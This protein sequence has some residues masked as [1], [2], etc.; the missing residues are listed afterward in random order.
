MIVKRVVQVLVD[1]A[2]V[3][4]YEYQTPMSPPERAALR[5]FLDC[6]RF[7]EPNAVLKCINTKDGAGR[8]FSLNG[9]SKSK[10]LF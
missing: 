4:E 2:V 8:R 5:L 1:E 10:D 6:T 9:A 7:F 3:D